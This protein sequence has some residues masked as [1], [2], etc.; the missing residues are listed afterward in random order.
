MYIYN[1]I[2]FIYYTHLISPELKQ[3]QYRCL[4]L[5]NCVND[6]KQKTTYGTFNIELQESSI[7]RAFNVMQLLENII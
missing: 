1:I 2:V 7:Y 6:L 3:Q 5:R 4:K